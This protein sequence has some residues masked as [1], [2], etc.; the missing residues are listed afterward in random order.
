MTEA[1]IEIRGL[2]LA[3]ELDIHTAYEEAV[4]EGGSFPVVPPV[5]LT[6]TRAVWIDGNDR[7]LVAELEGSFAGCCYVRPNYAGRGSSIANAGYLVPTSARG[8]GVGRALLDRSLDEARELNYAAMM[9]NLVFERNPAR[10][11]WEA[12]GFREIGRVP[13]AIDAE[14]D[15]LIY[16]REL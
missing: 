3:D 10:R 16:F 6:D 11:L 4:A 1:E 13:R 14:Q 8:R 2:R 9:F 5:S 15:A 12:A 7:V